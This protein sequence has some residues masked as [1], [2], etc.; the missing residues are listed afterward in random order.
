MNSKTENIT[1]L[2]EVVEKLRSPD[3]CPWD[4]EQTHESLRENMI[5]EAY[6]A[7]DAIDS[8]KF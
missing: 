6:E 2:I 4:K 7:I 8:R 1:K 5:Q 3:G